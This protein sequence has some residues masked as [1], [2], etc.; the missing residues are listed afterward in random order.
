LRL[1]SLV[2]KRHH[3][4]HDAANPLLRPLPICRIHH[5]GP[6]FVRP[7]M[8]R[9]GF[10]LLA[11]INFRIDFESNSFWPPFHSSPW[12]MDVGG[13]AASGL[14]FTRDFSRIRCAGTPPPHRWRR[15]SAAGRPARSPSLCLL[16]SR[17]CHVSCVA[18]ACHV[19]CV[20]CVMCVRAGLAQA[21]ME[22]TRRTAG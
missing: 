15:V 5:P 3:H 12:P 13:F 20:V 17:V 2:L 6:H 4:H 22:S 21:T 16:C 9:C 18:C 10:L 11:E 19:S 7:H 8:H 14:V 1:G